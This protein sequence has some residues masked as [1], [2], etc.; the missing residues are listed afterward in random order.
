MELTRR[1]LLALMGAGGAGALAGCAGQ[2]PE[3]DVTAAGFGEEA[4]GVVRVWTRG[5]TVEGMSGVVDAFHASQDRIRVELT[6]VLDGQ[7]VTKLATAIRGRE[8]PDLVDIDDINAMLFIYRDVFTDLTPLVEQLE[9]RDQLSPAHL[10]LATVDDRVYGVPFLADVSMLWGNAELLDRA[11]VDIAGLDSLEAAVEAAAAVSALGADVHGWSTAGN[12]PGILGFTV[13]PH[14]WATGARILEGDVGSQIGDLVGNE[15]LRGTLEAFRSMWEAGS[16]PPGNFSDT[17]AAWG[18]DFRAGSVGLLPCNYI[19]GVLEG[20]EAH[21]ERT[22]VRLLPGPG[23]GSA[24]FAGGDNLCMPRGARNPSAAWE[25]VRFALGVE[26]QEGLPDLGFIPIRGDAATDRYREEHP[27]AV[28]PLEQITQGY[29]P[30]TL[31]YNLLFNQSD[32]PYMAM[33]REAVF[34]RG[35]EPAVEAAQAEF[36]RILE[37]AQ[38]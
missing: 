28:L 36:D 23:G 15:G 26:Q 21:R 11:G 1:A 18:A 8:V 3:P 4:S 13:Q 37:Q 9:F 24:F 22:T 27:L 16:M 20:D 5:A 35:V 19:S 33:F 6:P 32:S 25:L 31:S 2:L 30:R 38:R 17:G 10:G 7:Y 34:G 14:T 12:N 29:A